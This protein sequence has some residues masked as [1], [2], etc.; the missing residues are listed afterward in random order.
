MTPSTIVSPSSVAVPSAQLRADGQTPRFSVRSWGD[1]FDWASLA[2]TEAECGVSAAVRLFLD[3]QLEAGDL[4][5][6]LSPDAGFVALSAATSDAQPHVMA[7]VDDAEHADALDDAAFAVD[8]VVECVRRSEVAPQA[9]LELVVQRLLPEQRVFVHSSA[10]DAGEWLAHFRGLADSG[11]VAAWCTSGADADD[12]TAR[13][14]HAALSAHGFVPHVLAEQDGEAQLFAAPLAVAECVALHASVVAPVVGEA[15]VT[16]VSTVDAEPASHL[17]AT[18]RELHFIAPYC[19]TGYGIAGAQLLR[20]LLRRGASVNFF[21]LGAPDA[22]VLPMRGLQESMARQDRFDANAPSVRLAQKFDLAMHVGRG[23]RIGFPIFELSRFT[24]REKHH[25]G[26]QDRVLVCSE[27]ARGI[28]LENGLYRTPIDIVPL[29]VDREVFHERLDAGRTRPD[30]IFLQVGKLEPRKNQ[31]GLL[32]A[33][34][35]A[36]TPRDPVQLV[37][38]C[39]NPFLEPEAFRHATQPFRRSP[40]AKRITILDKPLPTHTDIAKLMARADCGVFPSRAEGWNLEALEM[41]SVG[42]HVIATNYSAHTAFLTPENARLIEVDGVERAPV[43]PEG[44]AWAAWDASQHEQLVLHLRR[45][46]TERQQGSL[47]LNA[48]GIAT[49]TQCSWDESARAMLRAISAS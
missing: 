3:A 34:E 27:W 7:L 49:A 13:Q 25:L 6:D 17:P 12:A 46:H 43:G 21:P 28:L 26:A 24:A 10:G 39:H 18:A 36:F 8:V 19:R 44:A 14:A 22:S 9:L 40:M 29:G 2:E 20:A 1:R 32:R 47:G 37:L 35:A 16:R 15:V 30:T 42:R 38:A 41:L 33:F 45:V 48:A 4:V 5:V 23:P 11:V 31:L